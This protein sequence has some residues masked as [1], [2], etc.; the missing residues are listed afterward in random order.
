VIVE[1]PLPGGPL[2]GTEVGF[3]VTD[4]LG[5]TT[6]AGLGVGVGDAVGVGEGDGVTNKAG[7][8]FPFLKIEY[9]KARIRRTITSTIIGANPLLFFIIHCS[10]FPEV[11]C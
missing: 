7:E 3:G 2:T 11:I 9:T 8:I 6:G 4:G 1:S 10:K 5:V